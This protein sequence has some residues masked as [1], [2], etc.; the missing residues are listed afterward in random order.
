MK[1][2]VTA[3]YDIQGQGIVR[4]ARLALLGKY[5]P[6]GNLQGGPGARCL[7]VLLFLHYLGYPFYLILARHGHRLQTLRR[8]LRK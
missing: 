5:L 8:W 2:I 1:R 3:R 4:L 6:L 7:A